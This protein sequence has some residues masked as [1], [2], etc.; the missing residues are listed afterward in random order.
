MLRRDSMPVLLAVLLAAVP[1]AVLARLPVTSNSVATASAMQR[2]DLRPD[3][4]LDQRM[5]SL[6][7]RMGYQKI[8]G[9]NGT[10]Y[11]NNAAGDTLRL[12]RYANGDYM[13]YHVLDD[14]QPFAV[15]NLWNSRS[16]HTRAYLDE[17]E[18]TVLESDLSGRVVA[19]SDA[20]LEQF[21][22]LFE[23]KLREWRQFLLQQKQVRVTG[24]DTAK[25]AAG[26][27]IE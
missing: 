16:L 3:Q 26:R 8:I 18:D 24:T 22:L 27:V 15:I 19:A 21:I 6:L 9:E 11:F 5:E 12:N 14:S 17:E 20:Q 4:R 13:L 1:H 2:P 23:D 7:K 10:F 25:S